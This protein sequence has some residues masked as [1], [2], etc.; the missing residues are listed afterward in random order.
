M[1]TQPF[2]PETRAFL[3]VHAAGAFGCRS[4]RRLERAF[5]SAAAVWAADSAAL[6][7]AGISPARAAAF[8]ARRPT[9]AVDALIAELA[10]WR[11]AVLTWHD[12]AYPPLLKEI[13]D[14]PP[15]L[16]VRGAVDALAVP[17]VALVGSR[18]ASPYGLRAAAHLARQLCERRFAVVSGLALGIDAQAH[19]ATL[20]AGGT[21]VAVLGS[22]LDDAALA[23]RANLTLAH[24]II[25]G[26]GALVSEYFPGTPGLPH[27]FPQRNR[28]VAGLSRATVVVEAGAKSGALI[29]ARLALDYNREALAVPGSIFSP[30]AAGVHEL[31]RDGAGIATSADDICAAIGAEGTVPSS[32]RP[33]L[34]PLTPAE[35]AIAA[36]LGAEPVH[37]NMIARLTKLDTAGLN[38]TLSVME[39]K[40]VVKNTGGGNYIL[41]F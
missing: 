21:T 20:A 40:G 16:F 30:A 2:S 3:A 13:A 27:H 39:I 12:D 25:A 34:P 7:A 37:I 22:G 8:V 35:Q 28:I 11:I 23:P 26:G 33:P 17:A 18:H 41:N 15:L 29:T 6:Q 19:A 9:V 14:P 24:D 5:P 32:A 10:R 1:S 31:L 4:W 38:A 36:R